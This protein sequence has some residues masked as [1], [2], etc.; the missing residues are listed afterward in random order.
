[1]H[2]TQYL[3]HMNDRLRI[4]LAL[5]ITLVLVLAG[6]PD[7]TT[8]TPDTG[9][10][11]VSDIATD[12]TGDTGTP[13][14]A[15]GDASESDA[16]TD[17]GP[18][19]ELDLSAPVE[20]GQARAGI[21]AKTSDLITGPKA[22]GRIGDIKLYNDRAA[23][24]VEGNRRSDGYR[25]LGGHAVDIVA[26][27]P[28]GSQAFEDTFGELIHTWNLLIF[29]PDTVEI[30]D[31]GRTSGTAHVRLSGTTGNLAFVDSFIRAIFNPDP[32]P[33]DVIYDY[34]LDPDADYL[35]HEVTLINTS[36]E[37]AL[38]DPPLLLS[39]QGDGM[40]HF[41]RGNG[42]GTGSGP[43]DYLAMGNDKAGL[44]VMTR[45][46][47]LDYGF[48]YSNVLLLLEQPFTLA[49]GESE[50][51][52]YYRAVSAKGINDLD[53]IAGAL[54]I[55]TTRRATIN[56][57]VTLPASAQ[58]GDAYVVAWDGTKP[59]TTGVVAADGTYSLIVEGGNYRI[60]AYCA[61]HASPVPVDVVATDNESVSA[62]FQVEEAGTI[63]T[64]IKTTGGDPVHARV[65]FVVPD[66]DT[67]TATPY[68]PE[69]ADARGEGSWDW[70]G[71]A[72][73]RV[74]AVGY[75]IGGETT[76]VV[77]AG[78]YIVRVSRGFAYEIAEQQVTVTAGGTATAALTIN[79]VVD[80]TGWVSGDL[81]IHALRSPDS[82]VPWDIRVLQAA[83]GELEAP[84]LTEHVTLASFAPAIERQNV[85]DLVASIPGQEVT[86]FGFGHFNSFPLEFKDDEPNNGAVLPYDKNPK[87]L[88]E[89][90][91]NQGTATPFIQVNHPRGSAISGYFDYIGFN[92][93][94]G[95]STAEGDDY[96]TN[97]DGVEVFNG[98]CGMNQEFD[99]WVA[100]TN[101]GWGKAL[102][103]GS[104]SHKEREPIGYP[105]SYVNLDFATASN[106]EAF[107]AA[108]RARRSFV[109][110]GPFVI[111]ETTDGTAGLGDLTGVDSQ[112][113]VS[114][115]IQV[116]APAWQQLVEVRLMRNGEVIDVLP[117][118][119]VAGGIRINGTFTDTP[120]A[121][122]WYMVHVVGA[123]SMAPV[124]SGGAPA[125]FTN[126]IEVDVDG[127][128]AWTAPGLPPVVP[129]P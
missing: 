62:D 36:A 118:T 85:T 15:D 10:D 78:T 77:P 35:R 50:T 82:N 29:H 55:T 88:F 122:A 54:N 106:P 45:D 64:T 117:I 24:I 79:K 102:S 114:F 96:S 113:E 70:S 69:G 32:V 14:A 2:R 66:A 124:H 63:T 12:Q 61:R 22:D 81:H 30:I 40:Y 90:I 53:R 108:L 128:N 20:P 49:P 93:T 101:L 72:L 91:R 11:T 43:V 73:G 129:A 4:A 28:D 87:E 99:D 52:T 8:G 18:P 107:A 92:H 74:S 51:R 120:T 110:C 65:M 80:T 3:R 71:G 116:S 46:T 86:T 9:T 84:V 95:E 103:S 37:A 23:F 44:G 127:D 17:T 60:E 115:R 38:V 21:I 16:E 6:C 89:A 68:A 104:D 41:K 121:D 75:A 13:D 31:D 125:A 57:T 109:S 58:P 27:N 7:A 47:T 56:G 67:T 26:L 48:D 76:V 98:G 111:F 5:P 59:M 123:G 126:P 100:M 19:P 42:F 34:Y 94:T 112:G 1:M 119:E 97:W 83:T 25:Y 105:R 39:N 33:A